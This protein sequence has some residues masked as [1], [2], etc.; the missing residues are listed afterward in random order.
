MLSVTYN[1]PE[2]E[3]DNVDGFFE[4]MDLDQAIVATHKT[5]IYCGAQA[6]ES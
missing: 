5:F 1:S 3:F 2:S 6:L 4:G